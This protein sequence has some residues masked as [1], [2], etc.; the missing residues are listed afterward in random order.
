MWMAPLMRARRAIGFWLIV[1]GWPCLLPGGLTVG[2]AV[3]VPWRWSNPKP[4]GGNIVDLAFSPALGLAVQVAERGQIYTSFDL[5]LWVPRSSGT[6]NDLR[7]VT[8]LGG[9]VVVTGESG[10]VLYADG[11]GD[12]AAGSLDAPTADWL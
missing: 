7:A 3:P 1:V 8:F 6:T 11:D 10:R 9:R 2:A 12:F 5:K 4:H